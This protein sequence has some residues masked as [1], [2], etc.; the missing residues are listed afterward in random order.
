MGIEAVVGLGN[1]GETYAGT[2]HNVGFDAVDVLARLHRAGAWTRE[3]RSL[4]CRTRRG[5][6]VVLAKP[7]TLMNRSGSAV[8][9]L[10]AGEGISP[11]D[12]LVLVDDVD[13][14]LGRI[15]I[16]R[17]GG[18]GTHNGLRDIVDR[19]GT[20]F[21]RVRMGVRGEGETGDLAAY[22][23]SPF[24]SEEQP[25]VRGMIERAARAASC[26]VYEGIGTAMNRFNA[27]ST[28]EGEPDSEGGG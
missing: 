10:V 25:A 18:S 13:L 15:R 26:V 22:V 17:S 6:S 9:A 1:P 21:P 19:I 5:Q 4:T 2:R 12:V 24:T 23:L 11:R 14:P 7:Q 3:Y 8:E 20:G 27:S 28:V 16:R